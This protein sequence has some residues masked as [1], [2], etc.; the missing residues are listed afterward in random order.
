MPLAIILLRVCVCVCVCVC[1]LH[2]CL[3]CCSCVDYVLA[4]V[5]LGI[6]FSISMFIMCVMFV[7]CFVPQGRHFINFHFCYYCYGCTAAGFAAIIGQSSMPTATF[8]F[9]CTCQLLVPL[10]SVH[11]SDQDKAAGERVGVVE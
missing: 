1:I 6:T 3:N 10:V 9:S 11:E 8:L 5:K 4:F 7:Q 2:M